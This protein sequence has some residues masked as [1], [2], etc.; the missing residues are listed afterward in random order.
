M[1]FFALRARIEIDDLNN[2]SIFLIYEK[3]DKIYKHSEKN[4]LK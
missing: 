3:E 1:F 2:E 4:L